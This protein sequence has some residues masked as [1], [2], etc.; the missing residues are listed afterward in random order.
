[1]NISIIKGDITKLNVDAIVNA[2]NQTLIPGGGVDGAIHRA[3]GPELLAECRSLG[4]CDTGKAVITNGY[5]LPALKVIHTV[6]PIWSGGSGE[7]ED[8]MLRDCYKNSLTLAAEW[9]IKTI[10]FPCIST[11]IYGFPHK[12]ASLI[13]IM[14]VVDFLV[15]HQNMD[16]TF[17][18]FSDADVN[19]Y[20][21]YDWH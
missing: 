6:R 13:A 10:A 4:G 1:M 11:G 17:V 8:E 7:S 15:K 5:L 19:V 9:D 3:A 21:I 2:A 14:E 20:N 18:C 16:V 12:R